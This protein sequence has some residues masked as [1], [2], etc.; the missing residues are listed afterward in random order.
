MERTIT[1]LKVQKK[2]PNRVNVYLDG[3]FA[4]GL[5]RI[6]AAWL[7]V[8][9]KLSEEKIKSLQQQDADEVAYQNGLNFISYRPRSEDEV[10][11]KLADKGY[12]EVV[13]SRAVERLK[14]NRVLGDDEFA[15]L[16]VENR[17][18]FRPR[19]RRMLRYELRHKGV[20]ENTI[21]L[22]LDAIEDESELA[23]RAGI[24]YARRLAN[25]DWDTFRKKLAAFLGRRG[26]SYGTA[27][28][29]VRRIWSEMQS[30]HQKT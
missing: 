12:D 8:G 25:L 30:E 6:T 28:P 13:I 17:S 27:D 14:N 29:V 16:W 20:E 10:R 4:F 9:Q 5:T 19:S 2:N 24:R 23:Y 3:E 21:Q 18:T 1:A 11:K 26:F 22:A 15:R 7:S